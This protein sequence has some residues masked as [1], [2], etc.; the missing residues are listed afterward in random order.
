M[1]RRI[2]VQPLCFDVDWS[3]EMTITRVSPTFQAV[4][5]KEERERIDLRVGQHL[6]IVVKGGVLFFVL[7]RTLSSLRG[8]AKG[9]RTTGLREKDHL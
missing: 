2:A 3:R 9:I 5:P 8:F 4:I 6:Q 7:E 1:I